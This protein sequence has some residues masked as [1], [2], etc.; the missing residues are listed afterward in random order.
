MM[1][2]QKDKPRHYSIYTVIWSNIRRHQY[3]LGMTNEQL[4]NLLG[5]SA[6]TLY[7]YDKNPSGLTLEKIEQFLDGTGVEMQMLITV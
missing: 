6:R 2:T 1:R 7:T 4:C 5:I 3:L